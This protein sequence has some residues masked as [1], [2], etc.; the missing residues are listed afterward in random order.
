MGA[1]TLLLL[2]VQNGTVDPL[3]CPE[4]Y[5]QGLTSALAAARS[6]QLNVVHVITAYR[7]GYPENTPTNSSVPGVAARG[8]FKEGDPSVQV[9]ASVTPAPTEPVITKRRVS[10]FF[11]TELDMILRCSQTDHIVVAGLITSGAVLSTVRQ[12]ADLDYRI[13]ILRDLCMDREEDVH[14]VLM[15]KVFFRKHS[16]VTAE[17]WVKQ[18]GIEASNA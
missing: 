14:R 11:G 13:T 9:H 7:N 8:L 17:V 4:S 5:L 6:H 16:V 2:D 10:A 1:T 3:Q 12:A 15:D 18:L